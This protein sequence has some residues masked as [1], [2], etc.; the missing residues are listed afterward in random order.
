MVENCAGVLCRQKIY[1]TL[2]DTVKQA[3]DLIPL[4]GDTFTLSGYITKRMDVV[5]CDATSEDMTANP[6]SLWSWDTTFV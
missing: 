3:S 5:V 2:T 6:E 1:R 4:G